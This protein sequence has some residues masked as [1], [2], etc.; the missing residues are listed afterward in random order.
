[1][2]NTQV[3]VIL[4]SFNSENTLERCLRALF[5]QSH[6]VE[7]EIIVV[8]SSS[9]QAVDSI[10]RVFQKVKLV[11]LKDRVSPGVARNIG[12]KEAVGQVFVFLDTDVFLSSD[13]ISQIWINYQRG[14]KIFGGALEVAPGSS[15]PWGIIEHLFF[16]HESL[17]HRPLSLRNNLSSALMVVDR[18]IF[19]EA[20][21]FKDIPRMQ[22]TDLTE[23]ICRAGQKLHFIP[24]VKGMQLQDS[25]FLKLCTK[26]LI[27]GHNLY[28]IRYS[29]NITLAKKL[30][31]FIGLPLITFA[32]ITRI[33]FRNIVYQGWPKRFQALLF[34][35][36]LY[37]FG[38]LWMVGFYR[39]LFAGSGISQQR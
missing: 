34:S 36:A 14:Y 27:N 22:D 30:I 37:L 18:N 12:T 11:K 31:F 6:D 19:T 35:P 8:D 17:P 25:S 5:D 39:A 4:P 13:A 2:R 33:N 23:R 20:G 16:N 15:V 29:P 28:F 38:V 9:G 1:M 10:C 7:Y 26:I 24:A 21:G 32:K 3:S